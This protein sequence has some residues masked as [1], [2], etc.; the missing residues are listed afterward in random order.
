MALKKENLTLTGF[1]L[2]ESQPPIA[3]EQK[4]YQPLQLFKPWFENHTAI[5]QSLLDWILSQSQNSRSAP[6]ANSKKSAPKQ[7]LTLLDP[8]MKMGSVIQAALQ[9]GLKG[10]GVEINPVNWFFAKTVLEPPDI[11]KFQTALEQLETTLTWNHTPLAREIQSYYQTDCPGSNTHP[12]R[13]RIVQVFWIQTAICANPTCRKRVAL[14]DEFILYQKKETVHYYRDVPCPVCKGVFD[15]DQTPVNR[16]IG[17]N[18]TANSPNDAAGIGRAP[19]KWARGKTEVNCPHC[20]RQIQP[21][22]AKRTLYQKK[23]WV[24]VLICPYC[25][26]VWQ[27]RGTLPE[28]VRCPACRSSYYPRKGN[29]QPSNWYQCAFCGTL[30]K[31]NNAYQ[32]FD[33][34]QHQS[35]I[36]FA[37]E[38]Y[39]ETCHAS[40]AAESGGL[41]G[42]T[43]KFFKGITP[44]DLSQFLETCQLW[45]K[46]Q[47]HLQFPMAEIVRGKETQ[48][49]IENHYFYWF[50]LFNNRQLLALSTLLKG[51]SEIPDQRSQYWLLL[52]FLATLTTNN[53]FSDYDR[54]QSRFQGIFDPR[55]IHFP[56]QHVELN[57]WG[58][59]TQAGTFRGY[60]A[61][62]MQQMN[63]W[64]QKNSAAAP[65]TAPLK[66]KSSNR[67]HLWCA[68]LSPLISQDYL[69]KVDLVVTEIPTSA[70][71]A[72]AEWSDFF[73]VWLRLVLGRE[74]TF[75][76]PEHVHRIE[77]ISYQAVQRERAN[78]Y[79]RQ[80]GTILQAC[81]QQLN[82][83]GQIFLI[84]PEQRE[85]FWPAF[86]KTVLTAGL[87]VEFIYPVATPPAAD[88]GQAG[89]AP[90][91]LI[92]GCR[93]LSEVHASHISD[94]HV[95][96]DAI[97]D[98]LTQEM[99]SIQTGAY[100]AAPLPLAA[101]RYLLFGKGLAAI[102]PVFECFQH[103]F[104]PVTFK[105]LSQIVY[106]LI[107]WIQ[108]PAHALP[109]TLKYMDPLSYLYF[110]YLCERTEITA[111]E[112]GQYSEGI[113]EPESLEAAGLILPF[114]LKLERHYHIQDP[115]GRFEFLK[116][117][118]AAPLA[119]TGVQGELFGSDQAL[120][121]P[122]RYPLVDLFH[123]LLGRIF[124]GESIDQW[125][126]T[127][128]DLLAQMKATC[129]YIQR[130]QTSFH[131]LVVKLLTK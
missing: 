117:K 3:S 57:L 15:W 82:P 79:F 110:V 7:P 26:S 67:N 46:Q 97:F 39:C 35:V 64:P 23:V 61:Q 51:I 68:S 14:F 34:A 120:R 53:L 10:E 102:N 104:H 90:M 12:E 9:S 56:T 106:M 124:Y 74:F 54:K 32:P 2:I 31:I 77:N 121:D 84:L 24:S 85:K 113:T 80:L 5:I 60:V 72:F 125:F 122:Y 73:Y 96:I 126:L 41:S 107:D 52:A 116:E 11:Q 42:E 103:E 89:H 6:R 36:P 123:L 18:L 131:N 45:S 127:K 111:A 13:A 27:Y 62:L 93:N 81:R 8:F 49:L 115:L 129:E 50:Q 70:D 55:S 59:A 75:F 25:Q 47:A 38:G 98:N 17:S 88:S 30:D 19:Q 66:S 92:L 130:K 69:P 108:R 105:R 29:V 99:Q 86:T 63:A 44:A 48:P 119:D 33:M 76:T 87:S 4:S 114:R 94:W 78:R 101:Q 28:N 112:L 91:R 118:Y 100:G 128:T 95:F 37:I 71:W 65:A 21:A 43:G 1:R 58:D 16:V 40:A 83:Q 22:P 20:R 109:A